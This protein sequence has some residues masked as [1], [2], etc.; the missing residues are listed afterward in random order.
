MRRTAIAIMTGLVLG[1]VPAATASADDFSSSQD[2][3]IVRQN[4]KQCVLDQDWNQ[5]STERKADCNELFRK[6][7]LFYEWDG[8]AYYVHCRSSAECITPPPDAPDPAG[9]IP[10]NSDVYDV[11]PRSDSAKAATAKKRSKA[12][13]RHHRHA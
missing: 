10:P 6:Y 8:P 13:R 2:Y 1:A 9:A 11:Q 3:S 4:L 12:S 5:L 7:V